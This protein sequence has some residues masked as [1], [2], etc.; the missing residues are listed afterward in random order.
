MDFFED[1]AYVDPYADDF[2][3]PI[4]SFEEHHVEVRSS[5]QERERK[6]LP[7]PASK[8]FTLRSA[9]P[10][11]N[12]RMSKPK[13]GMSEI[14]ESRGR[15]QSLSTPQLPPV[16]PKRRKK[17]A[18]TPMTVIAAFE[19]IS[20]L[21][22]QLDGLKMKL[23]ESEKE[24]KTLR[25]AAHSMCHSKMANLEKSSQAHIEENLKLH[26]QINKLN[27]LIKSRNLEDHEVMQKTIAKL[28]EEDSR[29]AAQIDELERKL[30]IAKIERKDTSHKG[31]KKGS[32]MNSNISEK[33]E[34]HTSDPPTDHPKIVSEGP[35]EVGLSHL[36][37]TSFE[38]THPT[39]EKP[40]YTQR[41]SMAAIHDDP[42]PL[43]FGV[44]KP[45]QTEYSQ[46][47]TPLDTKPKTNSFKPMMMSRK[48]TIPSEDG[49]SSQPQETYMNTEEKKRA[50]PSF[51]DDS[52]PS[53]YDGK[54]KDNLS[55][56]D[57]GYVGSNYHSN[58]GNDGLRKPSDFSLKPRATF[59]SKKEGDSNTFQPTKKDE[60]SVEAKQ[61]YNVDRNG[62]NTEKPTE[63]RKDTFSFLNSDGA[64][65]ANMYKPTK[66][67][68]N[69]GDTLEEKEATYKQSNTII[70]KDDYSPNKSFEKSEPSESY[71]DY[72]PSKSFE[73]AGYKPSGGYEDQ[74]A[75]D[76]IK[77]ETTGYKPFGKSNEATNNAELDAFQKPSAA[78]NGG[79]QNDSKPHKSFEELIGQ[80][81]SSTGYS[82]Q[83]DQYKSSYNPSFDDKPD[84]T[85]KPFKSFD[86]A[87]AEESANKP[88]WLFEGNSKE[89][90]DA[91]PWKSSGSSL[92]KLNVG[93]KTDVTDKNTGKDKPLWLGSTA[94]SDEPKAKPEHGYHSDYDN[95]LEE[96]F[97]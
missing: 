65:N 97:V 11:R 5:V 63:E 89:S 28:R 57:N 49:P 54:E 70:P 22:T 13:D 14:R 3:Q 17:V 42:A 87:K 48:P 56:T 27:T 47:S 40:L 75:K 85:N 26:D 1:D 96:E 31:H 80:K 24:V 88:L 76:S 19:E 78:G 55:A 82:F 95:D 34:L 59:D 16:P 86:K 8:P 15:L 53:Q 58:G 12:N 30:K 32:R 36:P 60:F 68:R 46:Y 71:E 74:I 69:Y 23:A 2:E 77:K 20:K 45:A 61:L 79:Y 93:V 92:S 4:T 38:T 9:E 52:K 37:P 94:G 29:K 7:V 10:V 35:D 39:K 43:D 73:K 83:R 66:P 21:T 64:T 50:I 51:L 90:S 6:S 81:D 62:G 41:K 25:I 84:Q 33:D 44:N 67:T 91:A 18:P 72:S